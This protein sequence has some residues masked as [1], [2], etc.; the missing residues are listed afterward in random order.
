MNK[1]NIKY[2]DPY[3][4]EVELKPVGSLINHLSSETYY[5]V[6]DERI[7]KRGL[8][9]GLYIRKDDIG[10]MKYLRGDVIEMIAK[11]YDKLTRLD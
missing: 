5:L 8:D 1:E 7:S 9:A 10:E 4:G 6:V 2:K 11:I 3:Y